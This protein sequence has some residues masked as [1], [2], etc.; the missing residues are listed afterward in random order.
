[1]RRHRTSPMCRPRVAVCGMPRTRDWGNRRIRN[2]V[3]ERLEGTLSRSD[4][5]RRRVIDQ[6]SSYAPRVL[7]HRPAHCTL[8]KSFLR[9]LG[10]DSATFG[11]EP[12][13]YQHDAPASVF[14]RKAHTRWRFVL[15]GPTKMALLNSARVLKLK[16]PS[17]PPYPARGRRSHW[18]RFATSSFISG[19]AFSM[20]PERPQAKKRP[21][22]GRARAAR[23]G[24]SILGQQAHAD[25]RFQ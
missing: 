10:L 13:K 18:C 14:G 3:A 24:F 5:L 8:V 16:I 23:L 25:G 9:R 1:M 15:V 21:V 12:R 11:V 17:P 22:P 20:W 4:G 6:A 19:H 7:K 2:A